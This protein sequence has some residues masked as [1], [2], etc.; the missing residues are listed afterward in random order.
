MAKHN[1]NKILTITLTIISLTTI[2]LLMI[3]PLFKINTLRLTNINT[4]NKKKVLAELEQYKHTNIFKAYLKLKP[5]NHLKNLPEIESLKIKIKLPNTL[6]IHVIEKKP[7]LALWSKG[8]N[9]SIAK[10]GFILN[11][12]QNST[13]PENLMIIK[14]LPEN[15]FEEKYLSKKTTQT[16]QTITHQIKTIFPTQQMQ[17]EPYKWQQW[18]LWFNDKT[19][20]YLSEDINNIAAQLNQLNYLLKQK[21]IK[22]K[23]IYIDLRIPKKVIIKYEKQKRNNY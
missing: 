2:G 15:V 13:S 5:K 1:I 18:I 20:I 21:K 7:W 8:K 3:L 23:I 12:E 4:E 10:D 22:K 9:V 19:P 6:V 17:L 16:L 14:N 11:T